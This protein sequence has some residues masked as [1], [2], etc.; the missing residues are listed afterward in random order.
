[1]ASQNLNINQFEPN[2]IRGQVSLN[3]AK[4]GTFTAQVSANQATALHAGDSVI[5]DPAA[6]GPVPQVIAAA[7]SDPKAFYIIF[8]KQ[9]DVFSAGDVV[10][11]TGCFGPVLFLEAKGTIA[12]GATVEDVVAS[13]QVQTLAAAKAR[14]IA[15]LNGTDGNLLP[16]ML[17]TPCV[18]AS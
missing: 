6:T 13:N 16:I 10:E 3:I 8:N 2:P 18:A 17:T 7:N 14:G 4:R 11:I 5:L 9:T 1:M 12:M 15:L